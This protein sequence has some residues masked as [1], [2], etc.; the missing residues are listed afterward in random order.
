M[1]ATPPGLVVHQRPVL[2]GAAGPAHATA[3]ERAHARF[4]LLTALKGLAM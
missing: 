4:E 1:V 2:D 3:R